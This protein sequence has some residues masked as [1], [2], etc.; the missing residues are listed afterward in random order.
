MTI[1]MEFHDARLLDFMCAPD[2]DG[3]VLFHACV[4]R[5]NG[6]VFKDPQESGWQ[7][8]RLSF[9]GMRVDGDLV[10]EGEYT[11]EGA[12]WV[13]GEVYD[14]VILLP[15]NYE[16]SIQVNLVMSPLF[17]KLE[18]HAESISTTLE[19]PWEFERVWN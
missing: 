15:A 1:G 17:E 11:S 6:V 14:N 18:I 13:N 8:C 4:Y 16:G 2:G 12:L 9:R 19:G 10:E 7:K 3:Y 5:S